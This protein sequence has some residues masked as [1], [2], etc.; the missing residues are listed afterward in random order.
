MFK[1][2]KL[3]PFIIGI[4]IGVFILFYYQTP[5]PIV[6]QYPHPDTV[7]DRVYRDRDGVCYSYTSL[8]VDCDKN[9]A[10][11]KEYPLQG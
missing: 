11:L 6:Y 10:T 9:E 7:K 4:C 3:I 1:Q 5:M 2:F 8:E